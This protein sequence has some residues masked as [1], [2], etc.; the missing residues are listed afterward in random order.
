MFI[1]K[2]FGFFE[3]SLAHLHSKFKN[4]SKNAELHA[5]FKSVEKVLK[6]CTKQKLL[7]K[8]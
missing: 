7:A 4:V 2:V 1:K 3:P 5:D 8:T 6:K